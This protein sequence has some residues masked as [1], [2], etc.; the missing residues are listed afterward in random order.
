MLTALAGLAGCKDSG[1]S[2]AGPAP[3]AS[4]PP[5]APAPSTL[6][7]DAAKPSSAPRHTVPWP[8]LPRTPEMARTLVATSVL[9]PARFTRRKAELEADA[10]FS[11][12]PPPKLARAIVGEER[13]REALRAKVSLGQGDGYLLV[14]VN[15][16]SREQ[17][18]AFRRLVE[19]PASYTHV[20]LEAF[21]ADGH[22][23]GMA[24][25]EQTGASAALDSYVA[26]GDSS[27]FAAVR[28]AHDTS[29]YVA[30]KLGYAPTVTDLVVAARA[31]AFTLVPAD[32][33]P[34]LKTSLASLGDA[35]LDVREVHAALTLRTA[36][37][38]ERPKAR[39]AMLWGDAHVGEA[40][41]ARFLPK[42]ATIVMVHLLGARP[43]DVAAVKKLASRFVLDDPVLLP[44]GEDSEELALVLPDARTRGDVDR[45][46]ARDATPAASDTAV[47]ILN[48][49]S[50]EGAKLYL[51]ETAYDL[52]AKPVTVRLPPGAVTY[53]VESKGTTVVGALT[54]VAGEA[55]SLAV[56]PSK[57]STRVEHHL[58]KPAP[59]P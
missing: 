53:V 6:V 28:E 15:H 23:S 22:W 49:T 30:W 41:I 50:D 17:V 20:M 38:G 26:K 29:D 11:R 27:S 40:G 33:P 7:F 42:I 51:G 44:I 39:V 55:T 14:G 59:R 8:S 48:V 19:V 43:G 37:D 4:A 1:S 57:R 52:S 56:E 36:L 10:I 2:N 13:I 5:L 24:D 34:S 18:E 12:T 58:P 9:R 21:A 45:V 32:M 46:R 47:A 16:A 31:G 54:L 35:L 25:T 3:S